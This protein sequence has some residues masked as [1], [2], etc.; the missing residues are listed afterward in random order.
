M[1]LYP[2]LAFDGQCA[3]AFGFYARVLGGAVT[4]SLTYG[5]SPM[6]PTMPPK[7]QDKIVHATVQAGAV[8]F[9]GADTTP[10]KYQTPH[11]F[12]MALDVAEPAAADR[13]FEAL[14][15]GGQ[16]QMP[17]GETFWAL[18]FGMLL[19]RYQIPWMVNCA[20]PIDAPWAEPSAPKPL[21]ANG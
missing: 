16:V 12:S 2:H 5:D 20:K 9:S 17:I 10:D 19:D 11:G 21:P 6:G 8:R 15:Q 3:E 14:A 1:Q 4:F 13:V 7:M 18:R